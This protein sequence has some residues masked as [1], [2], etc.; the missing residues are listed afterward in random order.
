[1]SRITNVNPRI[2][3]LRDSTEAVVNMLASR[4]IKVTQR[5]MSASV[6]WDPRTLEPVA[7]NVPYLP[8]DASDVLIDAVQGFI[9]HEV[10]HLLETDP[11]WAAKAVQLPQ[12]GE[13][14][15]ALRNMIEDPR[16]EKL[17]AVRFKGSAYNLAN[18]ARFVQREMIAPAVQSADASGNPEAAAANLMM[19]MIRA[20]AG[21]PEWIEFMNGRWKHVQEIVDKM[22]QD[23]MDDLQ[24]VRSSEDAFNLAQRL[25]EVVKRKKEEEPPPPPPQEP[26]PQSQ[27]PEPQQGQEPE[28]QS[29][30]GQEPGQGQ[31]SGPAP[32]DGDGKGD[33]GPNDDD[34]DDGDPNAQESAPLDIDRVLEL[35][36][37]LSDYDN[38]LSEAIAARAFNEAKTST[39][40]VYTADEDHVFKVKPRQESINQIPEMEDEVDAMIGPMSRE[41]ERLITARSAGFWAAGH[42]SGRV[43]GASLYK[44]RLNRDDVYRRKHETTTKD[45]AYQI[46]MDCSGSMHSKHTGKIRTA[47]FSAYALASMLDRLQIANE[48]MGFTTKSYSADVIQALQSDP[49]RGQYNRNCAL[50]LPIFKEFGERVTPEIKARF[51]EAVS[52]HGVRPRMNIDGESLMVALRR[53]LARKEARKI[54]IVL[55][56]GRPAGPDAH[57]LDEH[58]IGVTKL[59]EKAGVELFGIG[60]CDDSVRKFYKRN[61]VIRN[62]SELPTVMLGELKRFMVGA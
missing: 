46:V 27:Q 4:R 59:V 39:Y 37:S 12:V 29:G 11:Q 7:V 34:P 25:Y 15:N 10:G 13:E 23:L 49:L 24:N 51:I 21:Q 6:D 14:V 50:S 58:L 3:A 57:G 62:V 2:L 20:L 53:V 61:V 19:P 18:T 42:R 54:I 32:G 8:D 36:R 30:Q 55:S 16:I 1:M 56:D 43:H 26:P 60:I 22:P 44:L 45:V 40:L 9:D 31:E 41:L 35:S 17:Q 38:T 52:G 5:G 33:A 48:C 28:Q 47:A